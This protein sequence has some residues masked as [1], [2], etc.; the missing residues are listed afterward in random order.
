MS[1]IKAPR[2]S[3]K[4]VL[5]TTTVAGLA[6][7]LLTTGLPAEVAQSFAEAVR[8]QAPAVPSFAN[9]VDAVSPAVVSVRVQARE[10]VSDDE[11][12]FTFDFGG[13]GFEDLPE[14]H[15][16]RRFFREFAPRE[17]TVPI[18]GATAA[19]RVAKVVSVRGRKAPASSSPKT[20]TSSP[21][22]TSSPT[23]RPSPLS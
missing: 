13:R 3:L 4:T 21:T 18:V 12:N 11:S 1:T 15:P 6:A 8:V 9:V 22:T 20:V 5:K 16:L 2:P 23:A 17:M 7:V 10:R 19:V 14:D